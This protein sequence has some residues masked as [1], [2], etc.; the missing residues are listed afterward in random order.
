[1]PLVMTGIASSWRELHCRCSGSCCQCICISALS[2][3]T[4]TIL[5]L[6]C[7]AQHTI[8]PLLMRTAHLQCIYL[9][10]SHCN[11]RAD[12]TSNNCMSKSK[13]KTEQFTCTTSMKCILLFTGWAD[14]SAH[15]SQWEAGWG[16]RRPP[17]LHRPPAL[18]QGQHGAP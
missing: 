3:H 10:G 15:G 7:L 16:P 11:D 9:L 13:H 18:L 8:I 14:P 1:M 5:V 6:N 2:W 12:D 17:C 4:C